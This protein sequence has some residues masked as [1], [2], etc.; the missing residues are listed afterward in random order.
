MPAEKVQVPGGAGCEHCASFARWLT[1][2]RPPSDPLEDP[3]LDDP[4]PELL[5]DP[6]LDELEPP[7]DELDPPLDEL[8]PPLDELDPPLE[9]LELPPELDELPPSAP[10]P[11]SN[12]CPPHPHR[13]TTDTTA[14]SS[15]RMTH[16]P[17]MALP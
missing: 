13:A 11:T 14:A 6:P 3:P 9:L 17:T 10:L 5:L 4:L 15:R 1:G 12:V 2:T 8:D 16:L 7:L